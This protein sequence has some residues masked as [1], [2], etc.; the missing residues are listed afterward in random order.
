LEDRPRFYEG[1]YLG[2][3]DLTA[4]IDYARVHGGRALLGGH[5]WG[6]SLGLGLVEVPGPNATLNVVVQPGY[7]WDGFGRPIVVTEPAKLPTTLFSAY[8]SLVTPGNPAPPPVLVNVWIRYDETLSRGTRAGFEQCDNGTQYSRVT[9]RYA[10]EVGPRTSFAAMRDPVEIAGRTVDAAQA[11][12]AFDQN[13]PELFDGNVPHQTLPGEGDFALWVIPL[14]VVMYQPGSPGRLVKTDDKV[15]KDHA[16]LRRYAGVIAGSIEAT[17]GVVRVHDRT[18]EYLEGSTDELLRV[19]GDIRADGDVRLYGGK[20][21]FIKDAV[22]D[23]PVPFEVLRN[24][25]PVA[26][27]RALTMVIGDKG[28]GNN[29]MVVASLDANGAYQPKMTVTD[30]GDVDVKGDLRFAG[31]LGVG[32]GTGVR[33]MW[34]AVAAD[35]TKTAGSDFTVKDLGAGRY[36]LTFVKPFTGQPVVVV[37]RVHKDITKDAGA[38]VDASVTAVVDQ[39]L[40]DGA[41]VATASAQ[42]DLEDG[43]FTFIAIGPR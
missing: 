5:S 2:A 36:Q 22:G 15:K 38:G 31:L 33:V 39:A 19:E 14:G 30:A 18:K 28:D 13:A 11:L 26:G 3:A 9:E 27:T 7:A 16:S 25:D 10:F 4:V 6:I 40:K 29:Q 41:I 1:Q 17:G 24:N 23:A 42:G 35:A 32:S 8:D 37:S 12:K 34:G 20:V 21:E 43:P